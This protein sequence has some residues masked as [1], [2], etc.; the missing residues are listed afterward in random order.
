MKVLPLPTI[1][2]WDCHTCGDCCRTY[3]VRVTAEEKARI[4]G[5]GWPFAGTAYHPL[6]HDNALS[7]RPNGDCVFLGADNRCEMHAKF[8]AE[9]KPFACRLY[10]FILV[11]HGATWKVSLRFACPSVADNLGRGCNAHHADVASIAK[12]VEADQP[13]TVNTTPP[14]LQKGQQLDWDDLT[15]LTG[16]FLNILDQKEQ[17]LEHRLRQIIALADLCKKSVFES[18]TGKRLDEFLG[19]VS[20]ATADEAVAD[21]VQVPGPGWVARNLF[22]Q[23]VGILLR[24]DFGPKAGVGK[25][26]K[27]ARLNA[28]WRFA[29]GSGAVP[30]LHADLPVNVGFAAAEV[31][32]GP[33]GEAADSLLSR[34]FRVKLES[35]QF[36]GPNNFGHTYWDGLGSLLLVYPTVLWAARVMHAGGVADPVTRALRMVDENFGYSRFLAGGRVCWMLQTLAERGD[37]ARLIAWYSR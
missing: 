15:R 12:L 28:G 19:I 34:Y 21:P 20:A 5:Q 16:A 25:S 18:V 7:Q 14:A 35:G 8:G 3:A 11:P 4:D 9:A 2:N 32:H 17:T 26:S 29:L 10:P 23:L 36:C 13:A 31:A 27:L 1:Q 33:W 22:R 24:Q 6:L 37:V 30:R